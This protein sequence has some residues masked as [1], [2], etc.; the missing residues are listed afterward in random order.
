MN[1]KKLSWFKWSPDIDTLV[2]LLTAIVMIPLYWF[3]THK[4]SGGWD[5][6]L[7]FGILT[8]LG[9]NVLFPV[10]WVACR[11]KQPLSELG[12]TAKWWEL[13]LLINIVLTAVSWF[14]L[15]QIAAGTDWFPHILY[16]AVILW[17]PFFTFSWLQMR[18]DRSFGIIPGVLLAGLCF[19]AYH[20]GTYPP[21]ML[22][23]LFVVGVIYAAIFRLTANILIVWPFAWSAASSIGTLMGEMLF[24]WKQVAI[25]S[26][27]LLI[28]LSFIGYICWRRSILS[29]AKSA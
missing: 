17:E 28:Q 27:F 11:R 15:R 23:I 16:N 3:T 22:I 24:A 26:V 2:V 13:S 5:D 20:T 18:F 1:T 8:N 9:L 4:L 6:I 19:A 29:A 14:P 21:A 10:W 7:V 12:I 25:W